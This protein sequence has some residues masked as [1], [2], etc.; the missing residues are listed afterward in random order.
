VVDLVERRRVL[1]EVASL[2][3]RGGGGS[4]GVLVVAGPAGSGRTA[5]ADAAVERARRRGFEV[6]RGTPAAGRARRWV[7]TR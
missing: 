4:G 6:L 7:L 1:D 2:L 3:D 5:L